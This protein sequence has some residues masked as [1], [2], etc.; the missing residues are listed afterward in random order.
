M[1][2]RILI[3]CPDQ[4]I[5]YRAT[6]PEKKGV[7][8][9]IVARIRLAQNLARLGHQVTVIGHVPRKHMSQGATFLPLSHAEHQ[10]EVDVA[11]LMSSGDQLSLESAVDLPITARLREVLVGG[12]IP[13]KGVKDLDP[14][15]IIAPSNFNRDALEREWGIPQHKLLTIYNGMTQIKLTRWQRKKVRDP[16]SLVYFSHPSKGLDAALAVLR[17]LRAEQPR[18]RLH[19]FGGNALWGGDDRPLVEPGVINHGTRGQKE[20]FSYLANSN[21]SFHLQARQDPFGMVVT[22]SMSQGCIPIASPVGAFPEIIHHGKNGFLVPGDHTS[23]SVHQ[24]TA[25][26]ILNGIQIPEYLN[27]IRHAGQQIPWTWENQAKVFSAH[28]EW[29]LEQK[30]GVE[31]DEGLSCSACGGSWLLAPD[32]YHCLKCG[33]Y[34]QDGITIIP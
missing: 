20:V 24:R 8:G 34:S 18:F 23:D 2:Y 31:K 17:I 3:Y 12:T 4:H 7:G 5:S 11:L 21:F 1:G 16:Y 29:E 33:R 30:G 14:D 32:G 25:E 9:G 26:I 27:Y 22:E 19:V 13:I 6:T 10:H 15:S 28:W